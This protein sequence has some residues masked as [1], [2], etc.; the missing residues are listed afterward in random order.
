MASL[1][2]QY[3]AFP[4]IGKPIFLVFLA[5]KR[6]L[7][8]FRKTFEIMYKILYIAL[9]WCAYFILPHATSGEKFVFRVFCS[10]IS[11]YRILHSIPNLKSTDISMLKALI[12]NCPKISFHCF[13]VLY[14]NWK[15]VDGQRGHIYI[16]VVERSLYRLCLT[17]NRHISLLSNLLFSQDVQFH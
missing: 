8:L 4:V 12:H 5:C 13:H 14:W 16:H 2:R 11:G 6:A 3:V 1:D 9:P 10:S 7:S 17:L 15:L